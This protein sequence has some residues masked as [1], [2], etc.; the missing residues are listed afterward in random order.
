MELFGF[1]ISK[2]G[3]KNDAIQSPVAPE[4]A[5]VNYNGTFGINESSFLRSYQT[6]QDTRGKIQARRQLFEN[7]EIIFAVDEIVNEMVDFDIAN[8]LEINI[9]DCK[10]IPEKL[11]DTIYET[12]NE[13][14]KFFNR[15]LARY[16]QDWYVDGA[17]A[18][19]VQLSSDKKRVVDL[20]KI[21]DISVL[22]YVS[23]V[24]IS[25]TDLGVD[26][27]IEEEPYWIYSQKD[28]GSIKKIKLPLESIIWIGTPNS[29]KGECKSY[30][31]YAIKPMN[32]LLT[33]ENASVIYRITRAPEKRAFYV[34]TG[35]LS[36]TKADEMVKSLMNRFKTKTEYDSK[37]GK[38]T[39]S[40]K[41]LIAATVDYFLPRR[42]GS[43]GT[44]IDVINESSNSLSNIIEEVDYL[45]SKLYSALF[46]PKSRVQDDPSFTFG[47]SGTITRE[48]VKFHQL[49]NKL[50]KSF[51][52]GFTEV[53][54]LQL[55]LSN[56]VNE[57]EW[58]DVED[59]V[60]F[61]LKNND[62][63]ADTKKNE[64][65]DTKF[66]LLRD[67]EEYGGK[68]FSLEYIRKEILAMSSE[69][70]E[71]MDKQ[72]ADEEKKGLYKTDEEL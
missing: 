8:P 52:A 41:N 51:M 49:V 55:I 32:D 33:L 7:S 21:I 24:K 2:K 29:K 18:F 48:E 20:K 1:E 50:E 16:L 3:K 69:E 39:T 58:V 67:A 46:I 38:V 66:S 26:T 61:R 40:N 12:S 27:Y 37:T 56:V 13:M 72:M 36:P 6:E 54:K 57:E 62:F 9:E 68:Y 43:T 23:P 11:A 35:Q 15:D 25:R 42:E 45:K 22:E 34:D 70:I 71:E 44:E 10:E 4:E 17:I 64:N 5:Y 60:R 53:V 30:I 19:F 47:N 65:L 28:G 59:K 63:F 31:D 14:F